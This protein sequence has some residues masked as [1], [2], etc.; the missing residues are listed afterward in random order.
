MRHPA[1]ACGIY[2][3]KPTFE[4]ISTTGVVPLSGSCDHVGVLCRSA[5]DLPL[6]TGEIAARSA[7]RQAYQALTLTT[8]RG[9]P[10][11][12]VVVAVKRMHR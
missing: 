7:E 10:R 6:I 2:G 11:G 3:F 4:A 12:A 5:H 1:S 9:S 8:S